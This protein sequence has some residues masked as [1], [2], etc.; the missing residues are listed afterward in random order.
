MS[1]QATKEAPAEVKEFTARH[2]FAHI[3]ARKARYV[4]DLIRGRTVNEALELLQFTP[5]RGSAFY[6]KVLRSAVANAS[7]DE[8]VNM[9]RL[10]VS[11]CRA[12]DGP[13]LQGR[14]RYRPGPQGR[15]MPFARRLSHLV[16]K[17]REIEGE[18]APRRSIETPV[19]AAE[20]KPKAKKAAA[21]KSKAAKEPKA[22]KPAKGAEK[23]KGKKA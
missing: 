2:R 15:A 7:H 1:A 18:A 5:N 6:S 14:L 23:K 19:P 12:D 16:V 9:N 8:S 4:A 20:A 11:E 21:P 3:T 10:F 13:L 17:V 22:E